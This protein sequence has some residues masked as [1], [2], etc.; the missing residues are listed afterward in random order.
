MHEMCALIFYV[1]SQQ[2]K[3]RDII[4]AES[5]CAFTTL[6]VRFRDWFDKECDNKPTGL[7]ECFKNIDTVFKLYDVELWKYLTSS[8]LDLTCYCFRWVSMLFLDDYDVDDVIVI[9][10]RLLCGFDTQQ[11]HIEI[12]CICVDMIVLC[13]DKLMKMEPEYCLKELM[14]LHLNVDL[15][16]KKAT[17][18]RKF[19][20]SKHIFQSV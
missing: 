2:N 6:I 5:Y 7:R 1:F 12:I 17:K 11:I 16:L 19:V 4:E 14:N 3:S 9:L 18:I 10:D 20:E 15:V 8:N 13:K